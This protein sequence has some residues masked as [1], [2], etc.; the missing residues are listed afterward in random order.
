M[1]KPSWMRRCWSDLQR[2]IHARI[3]LICLIVILGASG[4]YITAAGQGTAPQTTATEDRD[5]RIERLLR[6]H[7]ETEDRRWR[8]IL[9]AIETVRRQL[10]MPR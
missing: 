10:R 7:D 2:D 8:S 4:I 3:Y 9:T 1:L 6:E 5:D